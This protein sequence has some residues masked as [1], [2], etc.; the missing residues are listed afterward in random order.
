MK[1]QHYMQTFTVGPVVS[2]MPKRKK[3]FLALVARIR[4]DHTHLCNVI[5]FVCPLQKCIRESQ[6]GNTLK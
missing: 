4:A 6:S 3:L 2:K 5:V 1:Y